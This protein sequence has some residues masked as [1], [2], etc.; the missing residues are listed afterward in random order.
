MVDMKSEE[1]SESKLSPDTEGYLLHNR[2]RF[3]SFNAYDLEEAFEVGQENPTWNY[4]HESLEDNTEYLVDDAMIGFS[5]AKYDKTSD[6]WTDKNGNKLMSVD[7][8]M[9]MPS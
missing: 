2:K 6:T 5:S 4:D 1:Y 7:R 3:I 8:W 9:R